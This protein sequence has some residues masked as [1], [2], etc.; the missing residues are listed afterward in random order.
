MTGRNVG[1]YKGQSNGADPMT[2]ATIRSMADLSNE[3]AAPNWQR[4]SHRDSGYGGDHHSTL[5][6]F[7][8]VIGNKEL[9]QVANNALANIKQIDAQIDSERIACAD[10]RRQFVKTYNY[11]RELLLSRHGQKRYR[12]ELLE[13]LDFIPGVKNN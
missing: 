7:A 2:T 9:I 10:Y 13:L 8:C 12:G 6:D 1:F 5:V 4:H 11:C 3:Q